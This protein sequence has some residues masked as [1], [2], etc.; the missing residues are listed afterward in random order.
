MFI[1]S[2]L[3]CCSFFNTIVA[4]PDSGWTY[5][6][7]PISHTW[8][9]LLERISLGLLVSDGNGSSKSEDTKF[10]GDFVPAVRSLEME[11]VDGRSYN[12]CRAGGNRFGLLSRR[13]SRRSQTFWECGK[14]SLVV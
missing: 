13:A 9:S 3:Y 1:L 4:S 10:S 12:Q 5:V 2:T 14:V 11:R 6:E 8:Q 7:I